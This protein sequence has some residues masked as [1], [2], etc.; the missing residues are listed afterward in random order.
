MPVDSIDSIKSRIIRNASRIWGYSDTQDINS[1]D[2]IVGLL[3]GAL[4]EELHDL[5]GKVQQSDARVVEKMID[6][7]FKQNVFTHFPAH[8]ITY[9]KPIQPQVNINTNYQFYYYKQVQNSANDESVK[10]KKQL[11]FSPT[12][13]FDL[14]QGDVKYIFAAGQLFQIVGQLKET[15][16]DSGRRATISH[17]KL[18]LAI[19]IN[20]QI[21]VLDGLSLLFLIKNKEEEERFYYMLSLAKW[22]INGQEVEFTIGLAN[23]EKNE[24]NSFTEMIR[25]ENNLSHKTC[26]YV[27]ELYGKHFVSLA[28]NGYQLETFVE[29]GGIPDEIKHGIDE[30]IAATLPKNMLWIE[31]EFPQPLAGEIVSDLIVSMNCFPVI[32]RQLNE[33]THSTIKGVNTIPLQTED[34]FF[35][36]NKIT[37]SKGT[38]YHPKNVLNTDEEEQYTYIVRQGNIARFDSRDAKEMIKYIIDLS[39]NEGAAFAANGFDMISSELKQLDQ[40]ITRLQH[41]VNSSTVSD[42]ENSYLLFRSNYNYE[43]IY[44]EFWSTNGEMA[45]DIRVGS[46]LA[47]YRGADL[48]SKSISLIT[49]TNGGRQKLSKEEKLNKLRSSMLSK[50]RIVTQEDIKALCFDHFGDELD[51]IEI[52]KGVQVHPSDKVGL[53]RTLDIHLKMKTRGSDNTK[54]KIEGLKIR[55]KQGSLN[56][57]PYQIFVE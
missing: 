17:T 11:F 15:I 18:H 10:E 43:R 37:D 50:G 23:D 36:I 56:L 49:K 45:N 8:A 47:L 30:K 12:A 52:K 6:L 19:D 51:K 57:L 39:R 7:L 31:I 48:D 25:E 13:S 5:S 2:P 46:S 16:A 14:F 20:E 53:V 40:I 22:K 29:H 35:D 33:S 34:I 26:K 9:A 4:A 44:I 42:E 32:N 27:N 28:R 54:Q 21:T 24:N 41:R 38:V 1:F 55:L 3:I